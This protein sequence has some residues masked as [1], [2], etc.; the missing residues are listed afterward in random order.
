[1]KISWRDQKTGGISISD[2]NKIHYWLK[3]QFG[4]A[5]KCEINKCISKPTRFEWA[6]KKGS[7]Y[8]KR[9]ENFLQACTHCHKVYDFK[10]DRRKKKCGIC[11][12]A[13][14]GYRSQ[15]Y[16]HECSP[17]VHKTQIK[18]W[19]KINQDHMRSYFRLYMRSY[20]KIKK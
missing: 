18:Q 8:E 10:I 12:N 5:K 1:M 15:K 14:Q 9:R 11:K 4:K 13:Y 20:R 3:M 6:L 7:A 16:C 2:Y 19:R 17:D